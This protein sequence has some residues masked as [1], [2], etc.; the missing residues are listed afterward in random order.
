MQSGTFD[1]RRTWVRFPG[2]AVWERG[3]GPRN[4]NVPQLPG[5]NWSDQCVPPPPPIKV[6]EDMSAWRIVWME[7]IDPFR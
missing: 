2:P 7:L 3:C 1:T 4:A 6:S 5:P